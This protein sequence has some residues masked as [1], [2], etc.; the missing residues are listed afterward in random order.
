MGG[1][2]NRY[3]GKQIYRVRWTKGQDN[4][5]HLDTH[6]DSGPAGVSS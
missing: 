5:E 4:E 2:K 6:P 1:E 3:I